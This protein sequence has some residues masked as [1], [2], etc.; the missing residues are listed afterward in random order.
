MTVHIRT[1]TIDDQDAIVEVFLECWR[2][3]YAGLL[4]Q[5]AIDAM[6]DR[7]AASLWTDLLME[8]P[9]TVCVAEDGHKVMGVTRFEILDGIGIVQSL[10]VYPHAQGR[11]MGAL[12][13]KEART[14][15]GAGGAHI[16]QLWVFADNA[17]S[18]GFYRRLGWLPDGHSRTQEEFGVPELRLTFQKVLP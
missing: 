13:L 5:F 3:S 15:M 16:L 17:P 18:I 2:Q 10:Y 12:L 6:T 4:P 14:S 1:A 9:G 7:R 11:G 8:G